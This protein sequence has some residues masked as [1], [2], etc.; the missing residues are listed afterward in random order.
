MGF[1]PRQKG[2]KLYDL[3]TKTFIVSRNVVFHEHVYPSKAD[4]LE[5]DNFKK[6]IPLPVVPSLPN[7]PFNII[8]LYAPP[9]NISPSNISTSFSPLV[10]SSQSIDESEATLDCVPNIPNV[11]DT[12]VVQDVYRHSDRPKRQPL[13]LRDYICQVNDHTH[14]NK[15]SRSASL[16]S[17]SPPTYPFI[18]PK[19]FTAAH[20]V[21][22]ANSSAI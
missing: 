14:R 22:I 11:H 4:T 12:E 10:T 5:P 3:D 13:W 6:D 1:S 19:H 20:M 21:F 2:Y 16:S 8:P 7:E 17:Y 18:L 9:S 15:S